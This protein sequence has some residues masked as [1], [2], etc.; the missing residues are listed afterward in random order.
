VRLANPFL[1]LVLLLASIAAAGAGEPPRRVVSMNL[2]TDQLA[3]LLAAPGQLVSVSYLSQQPKTSVLAAEALSLAANHGQAEE[4][5]LLQPDLI[6]AGTFTAGASVD[7]LRRLGFRV[8]QFAPEY[9][10]ADLRAN[11]LRMGQLLGRDQLARDMMARFDAGLVALHDNDDDKRPLGATYYGN[12]ESSGTSTLVDEILAAAGWRN[13][14]AELGIQGNG[15][16]PLELLVM[17]RPDEVIGSEMYSDLPALAHQ[18]YV[19]PAL[20]AAVRTG[21]GVT[22]LPDRYSICGGPFTLEAVRRLVDERQ[23][24]RQRLGAAP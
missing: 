13:L 17:N 8:E 21:M 22:T 6:L 14:A 20:I 1:A 18:N 4:I 16:L 24:L 11:V 12:G 2:C 10:F 23:H 5:F 7:M 15:V 9:S 3:I 19:H